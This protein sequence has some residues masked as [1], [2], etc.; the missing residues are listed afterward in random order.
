MVRSNLRLPRGTRGHHRPNSWLSSDLMLATSSRVF[1]DDQMHWKLQATCS[2]CGQ[3]TTA[4]LLIGI[5]A[6]CDGCNPL[7][8]IDPL[9][10]VFP[11]APNALAPFLGVK[12]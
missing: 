4:P 3:Q 7:I 5:P 11:Q 10:T 1:R 6:R 9:R 8:K 2:E 12:G